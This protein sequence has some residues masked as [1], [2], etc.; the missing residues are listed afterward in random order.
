MLTVG[1][2]FLFIF[3]PL[4]LQLLQQWQNCYIIRKPLNCGRQNRLWRFV[5]RLR[6]VYFHVWNLGRVFYRFLY[7]SWLLQIWNAIVICIFWTIYIV[8]CTIWDGSK[9][10][11]CIFW[12]MKSS[13]F[14]V[15]VIDI[16]ELVNE[17][18]NW[19][20]RTN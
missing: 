14:V 12:I 16:N 2:S 11:L 3:S 6:D 4:L 1:N 18:D 10:F 7:L 17:S 15:E 19:Y 13:V 8:M 5:K 20:Q 9:S